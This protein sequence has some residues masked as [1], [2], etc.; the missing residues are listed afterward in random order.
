MNYAPENSQIFCNLFTVTFYYYRNYES[1]S[2][3]AQMK[4]CKNVN[5]K[6][7]KNDERC[8]HI[9]HHEHRNARTHY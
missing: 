7:C 9:F 8:R 5:R 4:E 3:Q 6:E 1:D 2:A